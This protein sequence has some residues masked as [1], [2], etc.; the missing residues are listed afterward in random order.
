[1]TRWWCATPRARDLREDALRRLS[2]D[3]LQRGGSHIPVDQNRMALV[4]SVSAA[5]RRT[6]EVS[7]R[8]PHHRVP[9]AG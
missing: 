6:R 4:A 2:S 5:T 7:R 9:E 8:D 1:M 3:H